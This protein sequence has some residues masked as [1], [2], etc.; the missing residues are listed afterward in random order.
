[1]DTLQIQ[2]TLRKVKSFLGVFPSD[3][4]PHSITQSGTFILNT[5]PH[6]NPGSH[7]LA[8]HFQPKSFSCYYFDS[9][10]LAP[11]VPSI[12]A[13]LKRTC[14]VSDFNKTQLRGLTT[15]VCGKYC[16]LFALYMDRGYTPKHFIS[17]F[18]PAVADKH[19]NH[20]FASEFG[21]LHKIPRGG[22]LVPPL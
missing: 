1:M 22:Q 10:G 14:I 5:D 6:T 2:C 7:W 21:S 8:I 13:F 4:L 15:I 17:L 16:C 11:Y 20:L 9:C 19:I 12:Q 3:L 18:N